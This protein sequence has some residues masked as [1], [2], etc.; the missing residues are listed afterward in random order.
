MAQVLEVNREVPD[1]RRMFIGARM[2]GQRVAKVLLD[3]GAAC[4]VISYDMAKQNGMIQMKPSNVQLTGFGGHGVIVKG[5]W[6]CNL[7]FGPLSEERETK[8]IVVDRLE[9]PIIGVGTIGHF[10]YTLNYAQGTVEV[11]GL[12][13]YR[14]ACIEMIDAGIHLN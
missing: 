12:P 5:E 8:F 2:N 14:T 4:N 6:S 11:D 1:R 9:Y 3:T 10:Q 7:G 13:Q